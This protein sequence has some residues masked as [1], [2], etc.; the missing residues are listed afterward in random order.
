MWPFGAEVW[1]AWACPV[2]TGATISPTTTSNARKPAGTLIDVVIEAAKPGC[3]LKF[4]LVPASEVRDTWQHV[5]S[6]RNFGAQGTRRVYGFG[7]DARA[8]LLQPHT[9][10]SRRSCYNHLPV[11]EY[12]RESAP[13]SSAL[14]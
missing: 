7:A 14:Q 3:P 13:R 5:V 6:N 1:I 12:V 11:V 2:P 8:P 9:A 4:H 10:W